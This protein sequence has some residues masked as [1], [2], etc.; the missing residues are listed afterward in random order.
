[1]S[2][3][4]FFILC[5]VLQVYLSESGF[6]YDLTA[7]QN[8]VSAREIKTISMD[9]KNAQLADVLKIFSQQSGLNFI[10]ASDISD[11]KINLYLDKVP[12]E[13]ALE[14]IL[15]AN[16]L[17][18]ELKQDSNIFVV[19]KL[20][21]P[22]LELMSRIYPL[23]F[24]SVSSS[25]IN[26][27]LGSS[28]SSSESGGSGEGGASGGASGG[29]AAA[30]GSSAAEGASSGI[31]DAVKS[32]L[33]NAGSVIEDSRTNSLIIT[34]IPAQFPNIE[35]VL[36]KLDVRIPQILIEV[37]MLDIS[38]NTADLL[39]AKWGD[40]F[41]ELTGSSKL[42]AFPF[43]ANNGFQTKDKI[44]PEDADDG[45]TTFYPSLGNISFTNLKLAIQFLKTQTDTK[46]LARPHILTL[47]NET[48][49]IKIE[50]DEAIQIDSTTDAETNQTTT[51][52]I[53]SNTGVSL[54]V[55][56]QA[57]LLTNE[58]T[59]A[60][61]PSVIE[62]KPSNLVSSDAQIKDPEKR[63]SKSLLRVKNGDT[64]VIGGLLRS[65]VDDT[66]T[67][68]PGISKIPLVGAAFRHK[69]KSEQQRELVI[70]ITPHIVDEDMD[71]SQTTS[72]VSILDREQSLN[73]K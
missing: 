8:L 73:N 3:K 71:S 6:G 46:S 69:N 64:V 37:E 14:R 20:T 62:A 51:T 30:G 12:V 15:S 38:K 54:R 4:I 63:G 11:K 65:D 36:A 49:E 72:A 18:Y 55:T 68:V 57:N 22:D 40:T 66:R 52:V 44:Q 16:S 27:T 58:I 13:E 60:V 59:L 48:A 7:I 19:K 9:F 67:S 26:S 29:S 33:S 61:E 23:R 21:Q 32:V 43:N 41:G 2:K 10:A 24:A 34:D 1:M 25:K 5:I 47:N 50:T 35:Q 53:R 70:F 31:M 28:D 56:P 17:T 45:V 39:G 42:L